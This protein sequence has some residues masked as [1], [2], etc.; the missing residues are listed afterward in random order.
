MAYVP[1]EL[2]LIVTSMNGNSGCPQI[3]SLQGVDAHTA[4]DAA[5]FITDALARGMRKG[6][7]VFYTKWDSITTKATL[8]NVT[9]HVVVT[10]D[11]DGADLSNIA[12]T[13]MSNSD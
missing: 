8:E 1:S 6:D 10:V 12:S 11:A 3:W 9:M 13:T 5:D 7:I 4:A 2:R